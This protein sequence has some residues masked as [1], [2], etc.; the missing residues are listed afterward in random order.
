MVSNTLPAVALRPKGSRKPPKVERETHVLQDDTFIAA[1][2]ESPCEYKHRNPLEW[3]F[4]LVVHIVV[5]T[6]LVV[7][8]LYFTQTLDLKAFQ[9][10]WL[11]APAPP[12][13]PPPP[14]APA[15]Q[16]TVRTVQR[17][18]T[19][20]RVMAPTV[21]PKR[22]AILKEEPLPPDT[23]TDG[24]VGGVP[25]G[26]P[27]GQ[28]GGV[29][30]GIIGGTGANP[31]AK[32]GPPPPVKRIVRIGG[33]LKPPRQIYGP[34]PEYP[35][36]AKQAHI[37]GTVVVDAVIDEQGNVVQAH[38][39]SGPGL[40][41]AAALRTV[42]TWKYQPTQLNGEPISVEMRVEVHFVLQ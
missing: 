17:L 15:V 9:N 13:P 40:L 20:G 11:I 3:V 5:L 42:A 37:E 6:A 36:I 30:G 39:I 26:I 27:G 10:T 8:P 28:V 16:R 31:V 14:A 24:I 38:V 22:V 33:D 32:V 34:P 23:G 41:M 25:G 29:L 19:G 35:T 21:I 1:L 2:L 12:A 7:A 18:M 4:S